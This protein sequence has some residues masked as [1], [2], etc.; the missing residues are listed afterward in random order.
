VNRSVDKPGGSDVYLQGDSFCLVRPLSL[1]VANDSVSLYAPTMTVEE[2]IDR[3][4]EMP[5]DAQVVI[6]IGEQEREDIDVELSEDGA[7]IIE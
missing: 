4:G 3:L 2:L 1:S 6:C 7:V 5:A